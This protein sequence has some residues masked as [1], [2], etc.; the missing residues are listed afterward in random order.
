MMGLKELAE[1]IILQS[2]EDPYNEDERQDC[3]TFYGSNNFIICAEMAEMDTASQVGLLDFVKCVIAASAGTAASPPAARCKRFL[4]IQV[5]S[6][7]SD[8]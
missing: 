7:T 8:D 6:S 5:S 1:G 3:I 4:T 2:V